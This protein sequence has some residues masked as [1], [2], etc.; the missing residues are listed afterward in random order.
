MKIDPKYLKPKKILFSILLFSLFLSYWFCS[1]NDIFENNYSTVIEDKNGH[2][3]S[4]TIAKDGQWRFPP[5]D[6]IPFKF[7]T[8]ISLFEDEY[9][10]YHFGVNPMKKHDDLNCANGDKDVFQ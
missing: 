9:F 6:S 2:L 8:A 5:S 1:P 4:A 10:Y 7:K 3:L